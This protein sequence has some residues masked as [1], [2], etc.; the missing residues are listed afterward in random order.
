MERILHYVW[1][2]KLFPLTGLATSEGL[3]VE[4][5]DTG[6]YNND[7]GPDFFN[8]KVKIGGTLWVGNVEIHWKSSDWYVHGHERDGRYDNVV[9]HVAENVDAE[10]LTSDGKRLPQ[11]RL[12][13]PAGVM[14]HYKELLMEDRYPPCH[15]IIPELSRL[16]IHSWMSA[17]Q[18]ERLEKK[19]AAIS[20]RVA[21]CGG[22]WEEG[23][24]RTLARNYGFG[25]NGDAFEVWSRTIPLL[26]IGHHRNDLFQIE[27]V[28]MGQAGLLEP[29]SIPE[30]HRRNAME[31]GYF[32]RLRDEYLY[33]AHKFGLVPMDAGQWRFL[34]LRPENFPYIRIAQLAN[35]YYRRKSGLSELM[36]CETVEQA[37]EL[38]R[39]QVTP[40]WET[41]YSFGSLSARKEKKLSP[42]SLHLL[43]LNTV[44]PML[45]A[46]GRHKSNE[47][48]C[49]RA[50]AF[51]ERLRAE[52]NNIVRMWKGCGMPVENAGDSQA[53]IQLKKEYCDRKDCLRC[54]IGYE[55]L[56][57]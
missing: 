38:M 11:M 27:A 45:F 20:R 40:Y 39:T 19:T 47:S 37:E 14:L 25:I 29:L 6:L 4:V 31:E 32:D 2:H 16:A 12:E 36:E 5:I 57:S 50:L 24:F 34:R 52:N 8:A 17:L 49:D 9:L 41:H 46:Y 3:P 55:Y 13:V 42:F 51:L 33:L 53:L 1:K 30:R 22:S 23:Y 56:K 26:S 43:M 18:I 21:E 44:I 7:A 15:R 10:I 54:R 48:M 35:L 28:F